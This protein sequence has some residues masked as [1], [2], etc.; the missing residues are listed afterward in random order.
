MPLHA[1]DLPNDVFRQI[2]LGKLRAFTR[3]DGFCNSA[4]GGSPKSAKGNKG[5]LN[6]ARK[7]H[8]MRKTP[9]FG[10]EV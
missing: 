3:W 5:G 2:S 9:I 1:L 7:N 6:K 4:G 10:S 8:L